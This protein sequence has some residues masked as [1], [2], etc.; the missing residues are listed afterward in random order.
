M[1]MRE[2]QEDFSNNL[3]NNDPSPF[4]TKSATISTNQQSSPTSSNSSVLSNNYS[5]V[6]SILMIW[7][8]FEARFASDSNY[9]RNVAIL[10]YFLKF[11]V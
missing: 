8:S 4:S 11:V 10:C 9:S 3:N 5:R 7:S 1:K 6:K 2:N